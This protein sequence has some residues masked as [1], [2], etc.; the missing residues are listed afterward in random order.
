MTDNILITGRPGVGKTTLIKK[1]IKT[2]GKHT[3]GFYTEEIKSGGHRKGFRIR[4][5]DGHEGILAHVDYKS[6]HKIGK[7][8]INIKDLEEVAIPAVERAIAF[9]DLIIMDEIGSME[10]CSHRFQR[11]VVDA[12]NCSKPVLGVIQRRQNA[13]LDTLRKRPDVRIITVTPNNRDNLVQEIKRLL[14]K[15]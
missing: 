11:V 13:F 1:A 3:G 8:G 7:Y 14:E 15:L 9:T 5:L 12:L 2:L 4:T 10:L 6:K